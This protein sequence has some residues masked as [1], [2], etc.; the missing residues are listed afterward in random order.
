VNEVTTVEAVEIFSQLEG[1]VTSRPYGGKVKAA[2]EE[3]NTHTITWQASNGGSPRVSKFL[4]HC[5]ALD[6]ERRP[7]RNMMSQV[8]LV[9]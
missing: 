7:R 4:K 2:M 8:L 5:H 3:I 1:D 6:H 9:T